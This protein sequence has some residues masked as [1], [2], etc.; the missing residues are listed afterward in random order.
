MSLQ[1]A[2]SDIPASVNVLNDRINRRR[3]YLFFP[4]HLAGKNFTSFRVSEKLTE[5]LPLSLRE[6]IS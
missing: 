2:G 3:P 4:A 5:S 1:P 6:N